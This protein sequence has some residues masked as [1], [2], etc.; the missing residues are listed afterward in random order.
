MP[1]S[2]Q[3]EAGRECLLTRDLGPKA[4]GLSPLGSFSH[5]EMASSV[6]DAVNTELTSPCHLGNQTY[7]CLTRSTSLRSS[8]FKLRSR[9]LAADPTLL[10]KIWSPFLPPSQFPNSS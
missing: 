3:S 10:L 4:Q 2:S 8:V 6:H 1:L 5:S 9:L 7:T